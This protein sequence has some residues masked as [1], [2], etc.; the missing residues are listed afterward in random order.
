MNLLSRITEVENENG[1]PNGLDAAK[2]GNSSGDNL[3]F[4]SGFPFGSWN[5]SSYFAENM[6]S[7]IKREL[8]DNDP[9]LFLN[10]THE[11]GLYR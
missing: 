3:F 2:V 1:G 7:G 11:V 6:S 8:L 4:S 10:N 5:D 9:K